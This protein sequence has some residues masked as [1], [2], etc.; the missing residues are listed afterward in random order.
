MQALRSNWQEL[1]VTDPIDIDGRWP[2]DEEDERSLADA[3]ARVDDARS[4]LKVLEAEVTN[5]VRQTVTKMAKD[6]SGERNSFVVSLPPARLAH[7]GKVNNRIRLLCGKVSENLRAALDYGIM[8][9]AQ[10]NDPDLVERD[11]SFVI[12][13]DNPGYERQAKRA[14]KHVDEDVRNWLE[15]LQPYHGNE[16]LAFVRDTSNMAKHRSLIKV[17]HATKLMIVL[18]ESRDGTNYLNESE[19]WRIPAG[20]GH[21]FLVRSERSQ[22][23]VRNKHDALTV[24]PICIEHVKMILN[25][26][27]YYLQ[28]KQFPAEGR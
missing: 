1:I 10:E 13:K 4:D 12:A 15:R 18:H 8:R 20:E 7:K 23:I 11:V 21:E 25:S 6:W 28:N 27:E 5:F 2:G 9:L 22:L 26:L 19:W 17:S 3:Y 14:L 24:L 16:I